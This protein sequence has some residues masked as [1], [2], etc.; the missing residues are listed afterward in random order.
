MWLEETTSPSTSSSG[1]TRVSK[2]PSAARSAASPSRPVAEA[3]VLP[4]AHVRRRQ[5]LDEHD[6]DELL[7]GQR[8]EPWSNG[9]TTSSST[10]SAATS[11]ALRSS[12][13]SSAAAPPGARTD[14]G[15]GRT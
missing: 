15:A 12:V 2:R 7:G 13:V 9:T 5:A 6:V 14:A 11:S 10:P 4:H 8:G 3:E 1:A